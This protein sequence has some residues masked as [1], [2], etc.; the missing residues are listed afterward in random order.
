MQAGQAALDLPDYDEYYNFA[1]QKG[2]SGTA[3]F[4]RKSLGAPLSIS[5]EIDN[6]KDDEGRSITL[7][8][9]DFYIVTA[10]V[11]NA[12]DGLA[13]IDFRIEFEDALRAYLKRL[14]L[15]KP[16]I[17]CGDLNVAHEPIDLKNPREN[18]GKAGYSDEERGKLGEL[19]DAGFVD[20]FRLLNPDT[21]KY[22][23][24]SYRMRARERNA[25]WRIDYFL[26]SEAAKSKIK[27]A[28]IL[29]DIYGSDHC[30]ILLEMEF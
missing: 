17:Y 24:W 12:R 21:V 18:Q 2:Y 4:A 27:E 29:T 16:V 20:S 1:K 9:Q 8:Y 19:L 26:V 3:I 6:Y 22:S 10:Y 15:S 13:R 11:P 28:E 7:E 23:W 30:P 14:A 5:Y 25:G